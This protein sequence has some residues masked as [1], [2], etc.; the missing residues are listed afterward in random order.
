M[1]I[2]QEE[3]MENTDQKLVKS[4]YLQT[5]RGENSA[6][7]W[8]SL[9]GNP[10]IVSLETL[11]FIE[12]MSEGMSIAALGSEMTEEDRCAL[13]ELRRCYFVVSPDFDEREYLRRAVTMYEADIVGG[14]FIDY[15]GLIMSEVC[16]FRCTYCIH[17]GNL[18]SSDRVKSR[19]KQMDFD[20]AREAIDQYVGIL[21]SYGKKVAEINFGGGEPLLAWPVIERILK[22]CADAYSDEID[23]RFSINTNASLITRE[24]ALVL[25]KNQVQIASSLDGMREGNDKVR[26]SSRGTGTFDRII[27]AFAVLRDVN[28]PIEGV[29][30]TITEDNFDLLDTSMIDWANAQGMKD[31]RIDI[32]VIGMVNIQVHEVVAKLM[33]IRRYATTF[34]IDIHGFWSRPVENLNDTTTERHVVFCGGVR[35]NNMCVNPSGN[36]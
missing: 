33:L 11:Q 34:G 24:I 15:L 32:D 21:R 28:Y 14:G 12:G 16:N 18:G 13:D 36:V 6:V 2:L 31:I 29:A 1:G 30:V 7:I 3:N 5:C 23:L 19:K 25:K 35:G 9:Y 26:I 10:K 27:R 20:T 4:C 8:H 22:Y 17:F